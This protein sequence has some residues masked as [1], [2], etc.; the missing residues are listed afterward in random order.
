MYVTYTPG[1][2]LL[3]AA[4][5]K[6]NDC[7]NTILIASLRDGI[8][9]KG[10]LA[11][12]STKLIT[13]E[14]RK[15][16]RRFPSTRLRRL[17]QS[18]FSRRLVRE[19]RLSC[20]DLICPLF[21]LPGENQRQSIPSMP[22]IERL[23]LDYLLEEVA[24]LQALRVPAIALFPVVPSE[25]K[26]SDARQAYDPEGL[27]PNAVRALK[28]DFPAMGVITD[29]ALDPYTSHG[30]DGLLDNNGH[31]L[32]DKTIAVL[33]KQALCYAESGVD[34]VAPSDMMDGRIGVIREALEE[35]GHVNTQI[36]AYSAK[37]ASQFYGPFRDAIGSAAQLKAGDKQTYQM[38]PANG[39]EALQEVA[40]DLAEGADIVMVKPGMPY[41]DIVYRIKEQFA[42]PTFVYQVS[43]EYAMHKA[44]IAQGYLKGRESVL[45]V[46]L[47]FKRAGADAIVSYFTRELAEWL[48]NSSD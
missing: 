19:A 5:P 6:P 15:M 24:I 4:L 37:Y 18:D 25:E 26:T 48:T 32:N 9:I 33:V 35:K 17:R 1:C 12:L 44:A 46:F 7:E 28:R 23:S 31:I 34:A 29:I 27:I 39:D 40:L 16:I 11:V 22:G 47:G 3:A 45:E 21:L 41:L 2:L 8:F 10:R 42:V 30:H 20:D 14:R 36:I 43:G 13:N 38:D